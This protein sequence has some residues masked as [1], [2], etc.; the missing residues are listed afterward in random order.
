ML[1]V[2]SRSSRLARLQVAE[3][4][5]DIPHRLV[6][7]ESI[8]DRR[9]DISLLDDP[10]ADFFTDPLDTALLRGE[11]DLA[12]HSAKDLPWPLRDGLEVMALTPAADQRDCLVGATLADLPPGAR[13]GTSSPAR[14]EQL[15]AA[16][17]DL[18]AE[19]IR[20]SIDQRLAQLDR[21]DYDAI[22]VAVCAL[23]RL[24]LDERIADIL[25]FQHHPLQGHLAVTAR[26]ERGELRALLHPLDC[27]RTF[28]R[29]WLVGAGPGDPGLLTL[30]A[31]RLLREADLIVHDEL[32]PPGI[33]ARYPGE[34]LDAGKRKGRQALPQEAT[35]AALHEAA[36]AGRDVVRLKGGDPFIFG[37]GGEELAY[38]AAR[39]IPVE[40]VPG[41]TAAQ[42]AAV[43]AGVPLTQRGV[44]RQLLITSGHQ[45]GLTADAQTHAVYMAAS[46]RAEAAAELM[47]AGLPPE[48]PV[49]AVQS[50]GLPDEA[51]HLTTL[52]GLGAADVRSPAIL[53]AG[54]VAG[55]AWI[56][57]RI[58]YTGL[59]PTA[60][61]HYGRIVHQPMI[62]TEAVEA[63]LDLTGLDGVIFT[64]RTAVQTVLA[65][66]SLRQ[67][68]ALRIWAIGPRTARELADAG[69][70][71]VAR[72]PRPDSDSLADCLPAGTWLYPCS[73]RSRNRLHALPG[74]RPVVCYATR[75]RVTEPLPLDR[76]QGVVFSSPS[77]VEGFLT[78]HPAIPPH[79][80]VYVMGRFT[81]RRVEAA[82][83][84]PAVI[85][86]AD[87]IQVPSFA[88]TAPA[89]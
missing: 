17:P 44:S 6:P 29:V 73:D 49:A 27:R 35:N 85:A 13:V 2:V 34:K 86:D 36:R 3:A 32:I 18:R 62:E 83:V 61:R 24:G 38:L 59:D 67:L 26:R 16:R 63:D 78:A 52:D 60:F 31:D 40:V 64:S 43:A 87:S 21:G 55:L 9:Q 11:A 41:V 76:F 12:V 70:R 4:L 51:I 10:P 28:G 14:H 72:P 58:L 22:I 80:T 42:C 39:L 25:P 77:T 46:R 89:G 68:N 56:P 84:N 79:L 47:A 20:G 23:Q 1:T 48:T 37:R 82:G 33:L 81:R 71:D 75:S 54:A 8:G 74:V 65:R 57:P 15:L 45:A 50:A 19:S 5:G 69:V 66:V 88:R 7:V 53:L 30:K